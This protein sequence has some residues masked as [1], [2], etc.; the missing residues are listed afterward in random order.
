[1]GIFLGGSFG[2]VEGFRTSPSPKFNIRLNSVLN[3]CG[4]RGSRLGNALGSL[5]SVYSFLEYG[6]E[7]FHVQDMAGGGEWVNPVVCA[8]G[9][10]LLYK[11]SQGPKTMLL[12]GGIG[13]SLAL[14]SYAAKPYL[15]VQR[16]GLLFF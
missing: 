12:A 9:A 7:Y 1:M 6:C 13:A 11:S 15:P 4:R 10:G 8:T 3:K 2:F 5:A 16:K 14:V